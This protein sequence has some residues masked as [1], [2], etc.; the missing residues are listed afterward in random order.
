MISWIQD[1]L[2]RNGRWIFVALLILLLIP[3]V[4]TI[5]NTPGFAG[6]ERSG[7]DQEF[8]G[9]NLADRKQVEEWVVDTRL[10]AQM[11]TGRPP[12]NQQMLEFLVINRIAL[13]HLANE[14]GIPEPGP[15]EIKEFVPDL[16]LFQK[17]DGSYDNSAYVAFIETAETD[18][19]LSE[20]EIE[21]ALKKSYRIS[22]ITELL[23]GSGFSLP[24]EA[25][26]SEIVENTAYDIAVAAFDKNAFDP[27]IEV[28]DEAL[29]TYF[30]GNSSRYEIPE[31]VD[32]SWV[33]FN[34]EA[35][36]AG[37]ELT[38]SEDALAVFFDANRTQY[39]DKK[40]E[41][42]SEDELALA[43]V[44]ELVEADYLEEAR[45]ERARSVVEENA[46]A[47]TYDIY[48]AEAGFGTDAFNVILEKYSVE[49]VELGAI[50]ANTQAVRLGRDMPREIVGMLHSL[51][52]E[53]F[54]TD[55][56]RLTNGDIGV[57]F[58]K[59]KIAA[60]IPAFETVEARVRNDYR[61]AEKDRLFNEEGVRL[62][63]TFE[64]ALAAGSEFS[65]VVYDSTLV[66]SIASMNEQFLNGS[67]LEG[68]AQMENSVL[69]TFDG[70]KNLD[71]REGLVPAVTSALTGMEVGEVSPMLTSGST[72]YF[73]YVTAVEVPEIDPSSEAVSTRLDQFETR[74]AN[75]FGRST[76]STLIENG[77]PA[78]PEQ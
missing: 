15:R 63:E 31:K 57:F 25:L 45:A 6:A 38:A 72:G 48:T 56:V 55:P 1:Q 20:A 19:N 34:L 41:G 50:A 14:L 26:L 18:P 52:P 64:A 36:A 10:G 60:E 54:Y 40:P 16:A 78:Q 69:S 2:A 22:K 77:A 11:E 27:E 37:L 5:G 59:E 49:L 8:Y 73:V 17:P 66:P 53:K 7:P 21:R 33:R 39:F 51:T 67:D 43:D 46:S 75:S 42:V 35:T 76:I 71:R 58:L 23:N 47:L 32:A 44:R 61:R 30:D 24:T 4:F 62:H 29:Q 9:V 74:M 65:S 12:F 68:L 28:T 13:S 70:V 3:F